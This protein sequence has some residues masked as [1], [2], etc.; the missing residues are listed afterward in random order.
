MTL[1]NIVII[2]VY[3]TVGCPSI[4]EQK[5]SAYRRNRT[6]DLDLLPN[7]SLICKKSL[8]AIFL[9]FSGVK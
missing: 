8:E 3:K 5:R 4:N 7:H 6:H 9:F 2:N 1:Y